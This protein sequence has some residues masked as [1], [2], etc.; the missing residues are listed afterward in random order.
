MSKLIVVVVALVALV[1][2]NRVLNRL[3]DEF[4]EEGN[5]LAVFARAR[6]RERQGRTDEARRERAWLR[7]EAPV[8][9]RHVSLLES[10]ALME[11]DRPA[12]ALELY[13]QVTADKPEERHAVSAALGSARLQEA[14]GQPQAALRTYESAVLQAPLDP[15]TPDIRRHIARLRAL[16]GGTG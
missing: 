13:A 12:A 11:Q 6:L 2:L 16:L 8:G 7:T 14:L 15:R 3:I 4:A 10:A 9:L 5:A 1:Y